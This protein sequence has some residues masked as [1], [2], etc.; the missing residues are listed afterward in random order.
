M[1]SVLKRLTKNWNLNDGASEQAVNDL[2]MKCPAR[3]TLPED[4]L[5]FL[6]QSNGASPEWATVDT[7][8]S[9]EE[10]IAQSEDYDFLA[11]GLLIFATSGGGDG[12]C[13]EQID[14]KTRVTLHSLENVP[15]GAAA[16]TVADSFQAFVEQAAIANKKANAKASRKS[17]PAKPNTTVAH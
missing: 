11:A 7:V 17:R 8:Y 1:S 5:H 6:R 12:Y 14:G 2:L 15:D 10:A 16:M 3:L 13:F 9:A 4:Y